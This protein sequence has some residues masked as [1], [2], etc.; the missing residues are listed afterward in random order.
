MF[1]YFSRFVSCSLQ[2]SDGLTK[3][4]LMQNSLKCLNKIQNDAENKQIKTCFCTILFFIVLCLMICFVLFCFALIC[5]AL[6]CFALLCFVTCMNLSEAAFTLGINMRPIS[7]NCPHTHWKDKCKHT[8]DWNVI[9]SAC[10]APEIV[11]DAL[12]SVLSVM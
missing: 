10:P 2:M 9:H 4:R 1:I 5:S 6:L 12:W 7:G 3:Q 11:E 8:S